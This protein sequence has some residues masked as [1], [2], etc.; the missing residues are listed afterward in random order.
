MAPTKG[1]DYSV[2]TVELILN[3]LEIFATDEHQLITP[4]SL[5][6]Q[7]SITRNKA[8]RLISTM[9]SKGLIERDDSSG[10]YRIGDRKSTSL[11]SSH[12]L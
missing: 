10:A 5:S 1:P 8:Y 6:L 12:R 7:L 3:I 2:K 4:A 11:N 9:E